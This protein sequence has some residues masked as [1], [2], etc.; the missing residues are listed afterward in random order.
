MNCEDLAT[1]ESCGSNS[2]SVHENSQHVISI[3]TYPQP[4]IHSQEDLNKRA[5]LHRLI[6]RDFF[7]SSQFNSKKKP[8]RHYCT[9]RNVRFGSWTPTARAAMQ[10]DRNRELTKVPFRTSG[11][12]SFAQRL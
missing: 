8:Y 1:S 12:T 9:A 11:G 4:P 10:A 3:T 2:I 6:L 7:D 5:V